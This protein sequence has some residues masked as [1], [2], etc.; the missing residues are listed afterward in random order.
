MRLVGDP[1]LAE[2]LAQEACVVALQQAPGG[3]QTMRAWL[4]T[5]LRNLVRERARSEGARSWREEQSARPEAI[6][7]TYEVF[8]RVTAHKHVVE[9]LT[10]L[11]E[12]YRDV[13]LLRYF[14]G[15]TPTQIGARLEM[16]LSSVK[17]RLAR[18]L[19]KL[20]EDL[21]R[22]AG[23]DGKAWLHNLAPL[24]GTPLASPGIPMV[25]LLPLVKLLAG[26]ALL[27]ALSWFGWHSLKGPRQALLE[28]TAALTPIDSV[29][30]L[31]TG[32]ATKTQEEQVARELVPAG[33][34]SGARAGPGIPEA[35]TDYPLGGIV[36]DELGRPV[37][38]LVLSFEGRSN[39]STG[40]SIA[41]SGAD[42]S[43]LFSGAQGL[44]TVRAMGAGYVTL[45]AGEAR[46]GE[47]DQDLQV[48]VVKGSHLSGRVVD[49]SGAPVWGAEVAVLAP[50]NILFGAGGRAEKQ[51]LDLRFEVC[52]DDGR[53]D[54]GV[55]IDL[56]GSSLQVS[57]EGFEDLARLRPSG[58]ARQL[59]LVLARPVPTDADVTGRVESPT[60]EPLAACRVAFE[61]RVTRTDEAGEFRFPTRVDASAKTHSQQVS[62]WATG[63]G[64]SIAQVGNVGE[65]VLLQLETQP[66]EITG[67][68][69]DAE[70]N[71]LRGLFVYLAEPTVF[72]FD[73]DFSGVLS[74]AQDGSPTLR[75]RV[76]RYEVLEDL[77]SGKPGKGL[78]WSKVRTDE[79][80]RFQVEGLARKEYS[81]VLFDPT[82]MG[83][84]VTAPIPAGTLDKTLT[85]EASAGRQAVASQLLNSAGE[86]A[87]G[88]QVSAW[89]S[90]FRVGLNEESALTSMHSHAPVVSDA[91]GGFFLGELVLDSLELRL[92]GDGWIS[93]TV[94]CSAS[95]VPPSIFMERALPVVFELDDPQLA[96]HFGLLDGKGQGLPLILRSPGRERLEER[97]ALVA[98]RSKHY[99]V[100]ETAREWVLFSKGAVVRRFPFQFEG[101]GVTRLGD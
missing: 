34:S 12:H 74:R 31:I 37:P 85:F 45:L 80:G 59:E 22:Q 51:A 77:A 4:S 69:Q 19:S 25:P 65:P 29:E 15:L 89:C 100:S 18:G 6:S 64:P 58:E 10:E 78:R 13:L 8:E 50:S 72:S 24:L 92:T 44:G 1:E 26:M 47:A 63:Y 75:S 32:S 71:A 3:I 67:R 97:G 55:A 86:P 40:V 42:G 36:V 7:S 5:V 87:V 73:G 68:V 30:G 27:G 83:R 70:G 14:D 90:A 62:A 53:F 101:S 79:Q 81:L 88:V 61:G 16:P 84:Q 41:I 49:E 23:G 60:G 2:D 56:P 20:R 48:V 11:P 66:L 76:L 21:D 94:T 93:Q 43:F 96:D 52:D 38:G 17:T 9:A 39:P 33:N 91:N 46:A 35:P 57:A 99:L 28:Q 98:G 95:G 54:L 82:S